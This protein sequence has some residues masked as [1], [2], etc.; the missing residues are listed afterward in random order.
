[1][2]A[3]GMKNAALVVLAVLLIVVGWRLADVGREKMSI[4]DRARKQGEDLQVR[5][6]EAKDALAQAESARDTAAERAQRL[7][8]DYSALD[9]R[10]QAL[11]SERD[12]LAL[13]SNR[14]A[15]ELQSTPTA[16]G[17]NQEPLGTPAN[18]P[19]AAALTAQLER[20]RDDKDRIQS[21][22]RELLAK[23]NALERTHKDLRVEQDQLHSLTSELEATE[24]HTNE[25]LDG[26]R[27]KL[28]KARD[29]VAALSVQLERERT[30]KDRIQIQNHELAAKL[31]A[32]ERSHADLRTK[33][34]ALKRD[35]EHL[36][37]RHGEL[38]G[39][40]VS[41]ERRLTT[42]AGE[43][44]RAQ[45]KASDLTSQYEKLLSEK[46]RLGQLNEAKLAEIERI[47]VTLEEAQR[48]VARLTS[49]RGIYT[50]K[51][52]DSLSRIAAFF[53]FD[54]NYWSRIMDANRFMIGDN[55]DLIFEG[56]V[57]I[58]P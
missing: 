36:A 53:Y 38:E 45:S 4:E 50:V 32:L 41:L 55:P 19:K 57:L 34:Q 37:L 35:R 2:G 12:Q 31:D 40:V 51:E 14:L 1:M 10:T 21:E 22:N 43:L 9:K 16:S 24:A 56:M 25:E 49:A 46:T 42:T 26:A 48:D 11:L 47:R 44:E 5:L 18:T 58:I 8:A 17:A 29:E 33:L 27:S 15:A 7:A 28:A 54:G 39:T 13:Q 6:E 30:E 20:E 52:G 23:L 3:A